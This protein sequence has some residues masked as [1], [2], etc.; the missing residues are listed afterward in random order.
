MQRFRSI[1]GYYIS[2]YLPTYFMSLVLVAFIIIII[3]IELISMKA[4]L[5]M[6]SQGLSLENVSQT[7]CFEQCHCYIAPL[8]FQ[9]SV[10]YTLKFCSII[11]DIYAPADHTF[12]NFC[13]ITNV[14]KCCI[15]SLHS[16]LCYCYWGT[17]D[18]EKENES[19]IFIGSR[20]SVI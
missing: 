10:N 7:F 19:C 6:I 3:V 8:K 15:Y 9:A 5:C 4:R 12:R 20:V 18:A 17:F 1:S 14:C 16:R 2:T 11:S 13:S